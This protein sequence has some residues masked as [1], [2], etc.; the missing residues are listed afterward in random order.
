MKHATSEHVFSQQQR[1]C[2]HSF[3]K[4]P[5]QAGYPGRVSEHT[6]FIPDSVTLGIMTT[7][8]VNL[9]S[10]Y[11]SQLGSSSC[12]KLPLAHIVKIMCSK[13]TQIQ[14]CVEFMC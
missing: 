8:V 9:S 11:Y 14:S 13:R 10:V 2:E 4:A 3:N 12:L 6:P 7:K 5:L 1:D